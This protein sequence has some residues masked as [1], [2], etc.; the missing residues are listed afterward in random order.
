MLSHMD[1]PPYSIGYKPTRHVPLDYLRCLCTAIIVCLHITGFEANK[2]NIQAGNFN[3]II[4]YTICII[5]SLGVPPFFMLSGAF[6]INKEIS[7][8]SKFYIRSYGRLLPWS[9]FFFLIGSVFQI[10]NT[11][12]NKGNSIWETDLITFYTDWFSRGGYGILWFIPALMGLYLITP[13]LVW[14]RKH[15]NLIIFSLLTCLVFLSTEY[16]LIP[17]LQANYATHPCNWIKGIFFIGHYMLGY[18]IYGICEK[19]PAGK[20]L[21]IALSTILIISLFSFAIRFSYLYPQPDVCSPSLHAQAFAPIVISALLFALFTKLKLPDSKFIATISSISII[22]YL[23]HNY[24]PLPIIRF[25]LKWSGLWDTLYRDTFIIT[26][27]CYLIAVPFA[28]IC[29][30]ALQKGARIITHFLRPGKPNGNN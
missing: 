15:T 18:C 3:S 6:M 14:V 27:I 20:S 19:L 16:I 2:L 29:A 24:L 13:I 17:C 12:Y 8:V 26:L 5:L 28:I 11:A 9:I 4:Y 23:S 22:I 7:S 21:T 25:G 30:L 10:L 1:T